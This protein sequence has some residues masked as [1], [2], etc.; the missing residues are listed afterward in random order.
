MCNSRLS[1]R[2]VLSIHLNADEAETFSQGCFAGA[3]ATHERIENHTTWRR[4]KAAEISHQVGRLHGR[5]DVAFSSV[6][7]ARLGAVEEPGGGTQK[8]G[9]LIATIMNQVGW[10]AA[11]GLNVLASAS[12]QRLEE[13]VLA[14][15]IAVRSAVQVVPGSNPAPININRASSPLQY[16]SRYSALELLAGDGDWFKCWFSAVPQPCHCFASSVAGAVIG[17][18]RLALLS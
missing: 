8:F 15:G 2:K 16:V 7:I 4:D 3:A 9:L 14:L 10:P 13:L 6:F 17:Y 12:I 1:N 5:V 11:E 18:S